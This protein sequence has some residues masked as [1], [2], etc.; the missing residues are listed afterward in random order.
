MKAIQINNQIRIGMPKFWT[1]KDGSQDFAFDKRSDQVHFDEGFRPY[2]QP[3]F[4]TETE[5]IGEVYHDEENDIFTHPIIAKSEEEIRAN[6][7]GGAEVITQL[8]GLLLLD[9]MGLSDTVKTMLETSEHK[10]SQIYFEYSPTWER[11]SP[12]IARMANLLGMSDDQLD[13][14]FIAASKLV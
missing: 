7:M 5:R 10:A 1:L 9:Q 12:I 13:D 8:Q 14:F 6:K 2:I 4:N 3:E 11:N